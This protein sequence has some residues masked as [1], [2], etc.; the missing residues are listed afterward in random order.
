MPSHDTSKVHEVPA[1]DDIEQM[2]SKDGSVPLHRQ[3]PSQED[4]DDDDDHAASFPDI[5][6]ICV[7]VRECT[8]RTSSADIN[9]Y[10]LKCF[11]QPGLSGFSD[12]RDVTR[13][14]SAYQCLHAP[15]VL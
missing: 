7:R 5:T 9:G 12:A 2:D 6:Y 1:H 10:V 8:L 15:W 13:L 3:P 14:F 4:D 11:A